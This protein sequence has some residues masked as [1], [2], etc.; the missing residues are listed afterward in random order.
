MAETVTMIGGLAGQCFGAIIQLNGK[1]DDNH[2]RNNQRMD[3]IEGSV[4]ELREDSSRRM[5]NIE[6]SLAKLVK[7]QETSDR[8]FEDLLERQVRLEERYG[9]GD[10]DAKV[11]GTASQKKPEKPAP[12]VTRSFTSRAKESTP[13]RRTGR[14]LA[15][16]NG[17]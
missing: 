1:V 13:A 16:S 5:D 6:G 4:G 14:K 11:K 2:Q 12:P 8:K 15:R 10:L 17:K 7:L 3:N 9:N